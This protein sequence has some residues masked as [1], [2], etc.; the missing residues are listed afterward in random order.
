ML[1][2]SALLAMLLPAC[3]VLATEGYLENP[4][5]DSVES[6]IG[7]VSGWHCTA[8][9][10]TVSI[11]GVSLGK[12]GVGSIRNDTAS[13]CGHANGGYSLLYNYNKLEPGPHTIQVFADGNLIETRSFSSRRSGGVPFL[14]GTT[15]SDIVSDFPSVGQNATVEWNQAK[16]SFVVTDISSPPSSGDYDPNSPCGKTAAMAGAWSL[17]YTILTTFTDKFTFSLKDLSATN[18]SSMPC[19]M[20]GHDQYGNFDASVGYFPALN[21]WILYDYG[22]ILMDQA[23]IFEMNGSDAISGDYYQ[24]SHFT[25][26]LSTPY[27]MQGYRTAAP[28]QADR[29]ATDLS[30]PRNAEHE[31]FSAIQAELQALEV[32]KSKAIAARPNSIEA[33]TQPLTASDASLKKFQAILRN[34]NTQ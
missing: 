12:S 34:H 20:M 29:F 2:A 15:R 16:Q 13:I 3:A 25:G 26:L 8:N 6:G 17:S 7:L 11:D 30:K 1:K 10:I 4:A 24:K 22:L 28:A 5:V 33:Q 27:L 14:S 9:Q 32:I 19:I 31:Q 21:K 23:F 18:D